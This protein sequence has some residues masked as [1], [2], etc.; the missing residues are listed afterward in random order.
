MIITAIERT[1]KRR[2]RVDVYVD[3]ASAF[4]VARSVATAHGLRPGMSIAREQIDAIVAADV[5][6][7]AL[8]VAGAMLA[9][10]PRSEREVRQRLKQRGFE[11]ALVDE[12]V[13]KLVTAKLLDDAEFA[14]SWTE[15]RDRTSPRGQR[16]IVQELRANGVA[17]GVALEAAS[18][19]S[20]EDAAYRL[21]SRRLPSLERLEYEAFRNRLGAYLQRRGFGWDVCRATVA[22]CWRELG[23]D[24][25]DEEAGGL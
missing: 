20:D 21:A 25:T 3:G 2:G 24:A 9:R 22:R 15:S 10:R 4:D 17:A 6:R 1:P 5:R 12:T 14:R 11:P 19:V 8:D 16:L 7:Q 23:R 13:R 18:A